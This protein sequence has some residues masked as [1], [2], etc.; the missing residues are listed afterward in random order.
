[1]WWSMQER[2]GFRWGAGMWGRLRDRVR[3]AG[4]CWLRRELRARRDR[5]ELQEPWARWVRPERP[6]LLERR[7]LR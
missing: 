1:M 2:V 5:P 7:G 6:E 3:R 4:V